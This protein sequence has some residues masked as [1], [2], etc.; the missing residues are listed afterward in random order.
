MGCK[1]SKKCALA[2]TCNS[3]N[4]KERGFASG[5]DTFEF[6]HLLRRVIGRNR[7]DLDGKDNI[8]KFT[9]VNCRVQGAAKS[10][11][12]TSLPVPGGVTTN[13]SHAI[14]INYHPV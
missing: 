10:G 4:A 11:Q 7:L 13:A 1:G 9:V 5:K 8:A 2:R 3:N 12:P 14:N 6:P